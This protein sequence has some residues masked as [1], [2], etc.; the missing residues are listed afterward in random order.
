M[1]FTTYERIAEQIERRLGKLTE[2][3]D[4]LR[5]E[6]ILA[7]RQRLG[8]KVLE[9]FYQTKA[10][11]VG[12]IDGGF[13]YT[14]KNITVSEDTD[15]E[16][17]YAVLPS[18]YPDILYGMGL[19]Q[20]SPTK[21]PKTVYIPV[22]N[23][24]TAL[25]NGLEGATLEGQIGYY[26]ENDR[27]YFTNMTA[28]NNPPSVLIKI[29]CPLDGLPPNTQVNIPSDLQAAVIEEVYAMYAPKLPN[30]NSNNANDQP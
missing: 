23:G 24:F 30:D 26:T 6:L 12:Q 9:R 3:S 16:A 15:L 14:F 28:S 17:Y 2:D 4:I 18:S 1:A 29:T 25:F 13:I 21:E 7:I 22:K 11:D 27:I 19:K 8:V 5:P 20:V 10:D